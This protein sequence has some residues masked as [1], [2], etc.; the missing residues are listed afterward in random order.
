MAAKK[1]K[2]LLLK[3]VENLGIV[4]DEVKVRPG[5][6]RNFLLPH[7]LAEKPT[8]HKIEMLKEARAAALAELARLR[9][10]R[11]ELIERM[12]NVVVTLVRSCNDQGI[13]YGSVTQRDIADGLHSAGYEVDVRS[14]RLAQPVRRVGSYHVPIQLDKDL[15]AEVTLEIKPDRTLDLHTE[16]THEPEAGEA[17]EGETS[18]EGEAADAKPR[19]KGRKAE[20]EDAGDD[21]GESA[22]AKS[23]DKSEGKAKA[24]KKKKEPA[25][26]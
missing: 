4:G 7:H 24:G 9:K 18:A 5:F 1:V 10:S 15:K 12:Q 20:A 3:S 8:A 14:V 26:A 22:K 25:E 19:K 17:A 21:A 11:E 23:K 2:L 13:L 16:P 6:A